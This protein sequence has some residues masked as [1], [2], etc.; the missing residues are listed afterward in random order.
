[1]LD[2]FTFGPI[3]IKKSWFI[4]GISLAAGYLVYHYFLG[5][6]SEL[7]ERLNG[8]YMNTLLWFIISWK[9]CP[10][11]FKPRM[12]VHNPLVLL[13]YRPGNKETILA[14]LITLGWLMFQI[15]R[16]RLSFYTVWNALFLI[17]S[18]TA[19]GYYFFIQEYGVS[20]ETA[21]LGA[22]LTHHPLHIY[23]MILYLILTMICLYWKEGIGSPL[24]YRSY[25][26]L[27]CLANVGFSFLKPYPFLLGIYA[28]LFWLVVLLI[29]F[30]LDSLYRFQVNHFKKRKG[31]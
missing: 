11:L 10:L 22:Y 13:Y 4:L 14:L 24:L 6:Q 12:F 26:G 27:F 21:W 19:F 7:R 31:N 25:L 16:K 18:V 3:I 8:L 5:K 20:I 30:V 29:G 23:Y 17:L 1:M 9:L 28:P 15:L 2:T